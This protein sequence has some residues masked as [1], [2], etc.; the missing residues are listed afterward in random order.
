MLSIEAVGKNI[1]KAIESGL[2]ELK[3]KR[4]DVEIRVVDAGGLFKKAKVLIIVD[5]DVEAQINAKKE[6]IKKIIEEE[7]SELKPEKPEK[8]LKKEKVVASAVSES[9][10]G[11]ANITISDEGI[12]KGGKVAVEFIRE[13]MERMQVTGSI[14]AKQVGEDVQVQIEGDKIS[15]IIGFRGEGLGSLQYLATII[16]GKNDNEAGRIFVNAGNY[17]EEREQS[18]I[19]LA[20][21]TAVKVAKSKRKFTLEP[22]NAYERKI[23]HSALQNDSFVQ[24]TS[25]G[26]EPRRCVVIDIK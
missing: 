20:R 7:K 3:L 2:A 21:R 22:M 8:V 19:R 11:D 14:D 23:I 25:I 4:E 5:E 15:K 16:A 12:S 10:T 9:K 6:K 17:K 24:T 1:D 26:E 13:I 18:L